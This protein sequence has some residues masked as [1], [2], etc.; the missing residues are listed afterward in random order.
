MSKITLVLA[1]IAAGFTCGV[2]RC[3]QPSSFQDA[4]AAESKGDYRGAERL[5]EGYLKAHPDDAGALRKLAHAIFF[6]KNAK[7]AYE[8]LKEAD[9]IDRQGQPC[10]RWPDSTPSMAIFGPMNSG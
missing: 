6:Q 2:A 10:L 3:E 8:K 1:F 7:D 5:Y 4:Q 9:K